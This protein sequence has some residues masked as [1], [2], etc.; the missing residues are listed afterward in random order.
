M[1]SGPFLS[2]SW[3]RVCG[4]R[5]KLRQHGELHRHTY[6]GQLS[7]LVYDRVK[8]AT[9]RLSPASYRFVSRMD[10]IRPVDELW[11]EVATYLEEDAPS[12]D[13]IIRFLAEL[14]AADLLQCDVSPDSLELLE[15][16][17]RLEASRLKQRLFNPLSIRISILDPDRFLDRTAPYI[18][19][20]FSGTGAFLWI[21]VVGGAV[22]LAGQY[23]SQLSDG[24]YDQILSAQN[25]MLIALIYPVIK[26]L[27]EL[28]HAYAVKA[29]G[30]AVHEM[31]I[32]LLV[33][34]PMPYVDA[35]A[36]SRFPSK[37]RRMIVGAAGILVELFIAAICMF[38]WVLVEPGLVRA[39]AFNA[40]LIAGASTILFNGNPLLRYD[41]YYI[42]ADF[43]EIPNL[44]QRASRYWA[45][46][47]NRYVLG[48]EANVDFISTLGERVWFTLYAPASFLYRQF[49]MLV[50]ALFLASEYLVVGVLLAIWSIVTGVVVPVFKGLKHVLTSP[51]LQRN[52][53][54]AVAI[55][56]G[57]VAGLL[58]VLFTVPAPLRTVGE[59]VV[60]L[61]EDSIVRAGTDG[62]VRRFAA[63][64]GTSVAIG[65]PL[66]YSDEADLQLR[67][68]VLQSRVR[69]LEA[70]F[71]SE[72][73]ADRVQAAITI[74]ELA[75]TR[76]ELDNNE[77][78]TA[79]LVVRSPA[80]GIFS[81]DKPQDLAGRFLREGQVVGYVLP[82]NPRVVRATV[83][84]DDIDLVRNRLQGVSVR[85]AEQINTN[86]DARI[87][88]EVPA[89]RDELPSRA[90]GASGGGAIPS[91]PRDTSGT[92]ALQR[93]FQFDLE[94]AADVALPVAF[95]GHAYVR[96]EHLW[97]PL[98]WQMWRR[99]RQL[100]LSRLQF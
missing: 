45:H 17:G 24:G 73:F 44:A 6:R 61:P 40:M 50:I 59:G 63:A 64:P 76:E 72:R 42:L 38:V 16:Y 14:H 2:T 74:S 13:D 15:R 57:T 62:F 65:T 68:E 88:R 3:Y 86:I 51:H 20:L 89:G 53:K 9:H 96:F 99:L 77:K 83:L 33:M 55:T 25:I 47:I 21:L 67:I 93:V 36:A 22:L 12:Q 79:L 43:L 23:A 7:Y 39:L 82:P 26:A 85:L 18:S 35:S 98:G 48:A 30:G 80:D 1:A 4:L 92:R 100:L 31:G 37:H 66:L 69:E 90:L 87:T 8:G 75:R 28:G 95:G 27:H 32:M 46:L 41:G 84:Q 19:W 78:R 71:A 91:D 49:V 5:P 94:L 81:I 58:L 56:F 70:Q 10:G 34:F 29:F 11:T 52:R 54:R 97:E 60:W